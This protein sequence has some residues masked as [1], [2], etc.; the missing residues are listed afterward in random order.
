[1]EISRR[2]KKNSGLKKLKTFCNVSV[3]QLI[4]FRFFIAALIVVL[5]VSLN[6]NGSSIG[7]WDSFVTQRDDGK[8]TDVIFGKNRAIRSDEWLVQTPYYLSQA[9]EDLP[10]V[11]EDYGLSGQNMILAYNSP[12]KNLT[13]LGK[14][15]NWGFLFLKSDRALSFYWAVKI[16]GLL[17]LSFEACLIVTRRNKYLS[18]L[19]AGLLSFSPV[20]Q[21]WFMQHA[22][23]LIFFALGLMVF[24]YYYW[25]NHE[26]KKKRLLFSL[27]FAQFAVGFILVIYPA[28]Q[29]TLGYFLLF[30]FISV[31]V[32]R[33][34]KTRFDRWDIIFI[35]GI[36]LI[37]AVMMGYFLMT[38]LDALKA[39]LNTIYPGHRVSTGGDVSFYEL[40]NGL[41]N[42]KIPYTDINYSNNS[43]IAMMY[44]LFPMV[45]LSFPVI[46]IRRKELER[47]TFLTGIMLM[48]FS[49]LMLLWILIGLPEFLAKITLLSYVPGPRAMVMFHFSSLLL[50]LWFINVIW[51]DIKFSKIYGLVVA[52]ISLGLTAWTVRGTFI[53]TFLNHKEIFLVLLLGLVIMLAIFFKIKVVFYGLTAGLVIV[54]GCYVNPIAVGTGAIYQKTLS[55]AIQKIDEKNQ[56]AL[57]LSEGMLYNFLP[58]LGVKSFNSVRFYPDQKA[59]QILDKPKKDEEYYNRYA[60]MQMNVTFNQTNFI[61]EGPDKYI[62]N[63]SLSDMKKL[64]INYVVTQRDL[65]AEKKTTKVKF[66]EKYG[67][68][69][70]G[71]RIY[72]VKYMS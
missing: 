16:V 65:V 23:D 68:D 70:D 33:W 18:L 48:L 61:L 39:T 24:F 40:F 29:V 28:H 71:Y 12:V 20:V 34:K 30:Y 62:M 64:K 52:F 6:V 57:W 53:M 1:M 22:G 46:L 47:E 54:S 5:L 36:I 66:T 38:S 50:T 63:I 49:L 41:T 27:L 3:D 43:E 51:K 42:W 32:I 7:M 4:R 72:K 67:P 21:W 19:G 26:N 60:H 15:F 13:I 17:L 37:I 31:L 69:R 25:T 56:N 10:L 59:W 11:N 44:D 8:T 14:P 58:A 2:T 45:L 55:Q 35:G 9:E